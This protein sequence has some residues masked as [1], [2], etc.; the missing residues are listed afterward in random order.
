MAKYRKK[1]VVVEASRLTVVT[2]VHTLEG[3]MQG[4]V[5]DWLITGIEGEQYPCRA[6]I[7]EKTYEPVVEDE[8]EEEKQGEGER[9]ALSMDWKKLLQ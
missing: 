4:N 8:E 3:T 1:P 2:L 9:V 6:D 7:F 5:G